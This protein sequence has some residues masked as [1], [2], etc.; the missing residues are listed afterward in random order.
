M[1][2]VRPLA[3][4]RER[5]LAGNAEPTTHMVSNNEEHLFRAGAVRPVGRVRP[6]ACAGSSRLQCFYSGAALLIRLR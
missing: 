3:G 1:G 5:L 2:L 4:R 6:G